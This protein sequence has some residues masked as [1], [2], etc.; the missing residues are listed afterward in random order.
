MRY[1]SPQLSLLL[2]SSALLACGDGGTAPGTSEASLE[3]TSETSGSLLPL[4]H[5]TVVLDGETELPIG[6]NGRALFTPIAPGT[7]QVRLDGASPQCVV[8]GANPR[9]VTVTVGVAHVHFAVECGSAGGTLTVETVTQGRLPDPD[10]YLLEVTG[11]PRRPIG[12][13][14]SL[15]L[16]SVPPGEVSVT[17]S[18]L[19]ANCATTGPDT[20]AVT[21]ADGGASRVRFEVSCVAVGQ[22]VI[23]FTSDRS[24]SQHLYRVGLDG[25]DLVDLTPSTAGCCGDWSPDGSRIVFSGP[26]GI[27]VMDQDGTHPTPLG[28]DGVEPRWSPDGTRLAFTSGATFTSDG[29]IHVATADG[30]A[31]Q[32]LG[33]GRSPDWSPDG[34]RIVF[35]RQ[36][37]CFL[38]VC[39]AN[40]Y[41]MH[42]DGTHVRRLT[43]S[44]G[45]GVFFGYPAWSPD[46]GRIAIRYRAFLGG[47]R[48]EIINLAG[49]DRVRL[50]GT[51][52]TGLPVWS[53][54]GSSL[55][56]AG[57]GNNGGPPHLTVVPATGGTPVVLAS[58]SAG[59][60][61][62]SWK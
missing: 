56:F 51:A 32:D 19:A 34:S 55:A 50:A 22:G 16:E 6:A 11:S 42:E 39:G 26:A 44:T 8:T 59:E 7:H 49:G 3:V 15:T 23:L 27:T 40:I 33:P 29:T 48:I 18:D 45:V 9:T 52:G 24:G 36:G 25:S 62:T 12:I 43:N 13:N 41:V 2:A 60:Y 14:D 1:L 54:D 35:Y 30:S 57:Y 4:D 28:L 21:I 5:Y 46:G 53:P 20:L 38:D 10:G 37:S 47:N 58:S 17:L 31:V 61:P